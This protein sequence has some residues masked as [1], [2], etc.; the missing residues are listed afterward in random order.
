MNRKIM[1]PI[2]ILALAILACT[3]QP[4]TSTPAIIVVTTFPDTPLPP[5]PTDTP[6]PTASSGLTMDMLRNGTYHVPVYDRTITLVDGAYSNG[7]TT[8]PYSVRMLDVIA[9]GDLNGDGADDAAIILVENTG[10]TGQFE[11]L[12]AVLDS[13]GFPV[14][15]GQVQLGDR[16]R[17]NTMTIDAGAITLDMFVQGPNDGMCCPSQPETQTY[18]MLADTLWMISLTSRTPDNQVRVI[19]ILSPAEGAEV[20]NPFTVSGSVSISPF[21]ATL[22]CRIY[23]PDG[24]S[25]NEFP[26]MVD[27]G[28]NMGGPGTFSHTFDLSNAGV[29]G[30]VILQFLDISAADGTSLAL[31]SVLLTIH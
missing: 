14:Q 9:M 13:G 27:S 25:V 23:L 5:A 6:I 15:A 8:D 21:E 1:L 22:A 7:S 26:L 12:V 2:T 17:I 28:G 31:A 3:L 24:T 29:T 4:A 18:R 16:V 20:S 30:P 10:G 19:T 11:S